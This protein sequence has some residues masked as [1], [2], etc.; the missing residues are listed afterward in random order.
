M[1][2]SLGGALCRCV[3]LAL[4]PGRASGG[5]FGAFGFAPR[6][7]GRP[8]VAARAAGAGP[9]AGPVV[10]TP[11]LWA[12]GPGAPSLSLRLVARASAG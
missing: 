3:E 12:P 9:Q 6:L 11:Q 10:I 8:V 4:P 2:M 7:L 5:V 1:P